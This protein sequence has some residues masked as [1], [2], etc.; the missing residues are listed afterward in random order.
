MFDVDD[1][2]EV[3]PL[4]AAVSKLAGLSEPLRAKQLFRHRLVI[5]NPALGDDDEDMGRHALATE[6]LIKQVSAGRVRLFGRKTEVVEND[7]YDVWGSL[8][9]YVRVPASD[10]PNLENTSE[11]FGDQL[12]EGFAG[13]R[14]GF[15]DPL[16]ALGDLIQAFP[17]CGF[18][19]FRGPQDLILKGPAA[20]DDLAKQDA[21][22]L[23]TNLPSTKSESRKTSGAVHRCIRW[24][25]GLARDGIKPMNRAA[26]LE[27]ARR[28]I[29]EELSE[30]GFNLAWAQAAPDEWKSPGRK[31]RRESDT[32]SPN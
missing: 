6:L 26:L 9:N 7:G 18:E 4:F 24:I 2:L 29:G 21:A 15:W 31:P 28:V 10:L 11:E 17:G 22:P 13:E 12:L 16:L 8:G 19:Q 23:E 1:F 3:V 5:D 32:G 25:E 27:Q 30:R 20:D 14:V